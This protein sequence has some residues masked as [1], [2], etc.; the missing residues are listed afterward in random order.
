MWAMTDWNYYLVNIND[1]IS[2][3]YLN[4]EAEQDHN[5][6]AYPKLCWLFIR[7]KVV[8]EDGLSHD[9]E[10]AA[11]IEYEDLIEKVI[12]NSEI[13]FIARITTNGMRKFY[14]YC[15]NNYDFDTCVNQI[16]DLN[17]DYQYQHGSKNDPTWSQYKNILYPS[18]R[19]LKKIYDR[20]E[21]I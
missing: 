6:N 7:L 4:L 21:N 15:A 17:P 19:D 11:L 18:K 14:F 20:A 13:N 3:V 5:I 8:R 16:V 1:H 12:S 9:D 2:S 10:Y